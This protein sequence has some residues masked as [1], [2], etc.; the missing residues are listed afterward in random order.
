MSILKNITKILSIEIQLKDSK[1]PKYIADTSW[2][3]DSSQSITINGIYDF[4][5]FSQHEIDTIKHVLSTVKCKYPKEYQALGLANEAYVIKY[6]PRYILYEIIILKYK[7]SS[8]FID[9]FAVSLA[10]ESKGAFF[11]QQS[12][13]FFEESECHISSS[14]LK[15]FISYMPL[16]TYTIFSEIY[17]KEHDYDNA[18]Y[19]A[20]IA[21]KYR[22]IESSF[23]KEKIKELYKKKENPPKRRKTKMT[24]DRIK[25]E[26]EINS[27][28]KLFLKF[29]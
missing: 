25:L 22:N 6:K 21:Q 27:A 23:S 1:I 9:K 8:S 2:E 3:Q 5:S 12:I 7:E 11:R 17:E 24:P 14:L 20:K 29:L 18:I 16:R 19:Y 15:D 10:Y 28:A 26:S 4:T 13:R